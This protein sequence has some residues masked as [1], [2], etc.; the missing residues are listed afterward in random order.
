MLLQESLASK[1]TNN[2]DM[3]S[4]H[5]PCASNDANEMTTVPFTSKDANAST[6]MTLQP[7]LVPC[8]VVA[9]AHKRLW[10]EEEKGEIAGIKRKVFRQWYQVDIFGERVHPG[11]TIGKK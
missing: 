8:R 4:L 1:E 5:S 2:V 6:T 10:V 3:M 11:T 7:S 9:E